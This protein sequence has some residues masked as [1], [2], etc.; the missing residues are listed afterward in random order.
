MDKTGK[1]GP[2]EG[3]EIALM[4]SGQKHV[5]KFCEVIF[6]QEEAY[7]KLLSEWEFGEIYWEEEFNGKK[8]PYWI[9]YRNTHEKEA[10]ELY[11]RVTTIKHWNEHNERRIGEILGYSENDI[12]AWID[13]LHGIQA[14]G[15]N[16]AMIGF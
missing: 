10:E 5:A 15:N 3:Q 14:L 12:Q 1:I 9:I 7:A 11:D 4:R 16:N 13:H 2:H 8:I 6:G